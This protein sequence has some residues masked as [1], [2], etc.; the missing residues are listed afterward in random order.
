MALEDMMFGWS[1]ITVG[2]ES[3]L[4]VCDPCTTDAD[5]ASLF[6]LGADPDMATRWSY[7]LDAE[8]TIQEPMPAVYDHSHAGWLLVA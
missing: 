7:V 3:E 6:E 1:E 8:F 2:P 4:F 5:S